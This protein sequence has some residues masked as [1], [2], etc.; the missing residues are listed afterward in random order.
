MTDTLLLKSYLVRH[1]MTY[2]ELA[3]K[4]GLSYQSIWKKINNEV[5]FRSTEISKITKE[6]GLTAEEMKSIFFANEVD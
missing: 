4:L 1:E 5:P 3:D 6:L 2:K